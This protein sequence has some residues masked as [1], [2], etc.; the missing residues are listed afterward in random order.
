MNIKSLPVILGVHIITNC[1]MFYTINT[2]AS[3]KLKCLEIFSE[4]YYYY[5]YYFNLTQI[6]IWQ[7]LYDIGL[8]PV[9]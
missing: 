2:H 7:H 4:F 3:L 5:Y 8:Q 1:Q 6:P 9:V